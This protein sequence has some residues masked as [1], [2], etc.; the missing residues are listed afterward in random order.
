[1]LMESDNRALWVKPRLAAIFAAILPAIGLAL[2]DGWPGAHCPWKP[3]FEA[4]V[5]LP[6]V[7]PPTV[8][9]FYRL[10]AFAPPG[11]I[12]GPRHAATGH[13]PAFSSPSAVW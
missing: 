3:V 12:G 7:L 1:M 4:A 9:G 8:L 10:A 13:T 2:A 5:A 6:P 11:P